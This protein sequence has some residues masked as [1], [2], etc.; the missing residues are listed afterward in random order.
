[1]TIS[2]STYNLAYGYQVRLAGLMR[3]GADQER[4][5]HVRGL[6]EEVMAKIEQQQ[7]KGN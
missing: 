6:Y 5:D 3:R 7:E 4:I 2:Q 1:M